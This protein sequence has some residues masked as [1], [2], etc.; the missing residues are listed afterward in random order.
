[1]G[2]WGIYGRGTH[3]DIHAETQRPYV[4]PDGHRIEYTDCKLVGF[5]THYSIQRIDGV[6]RL[7]CVDLIERQPS[8]GMWYYKPMDES[9][10]PVQTNCPLELLDICPDPMVGYST[11]WRERVRATHAAKPRHGTI[12]VGD[13]IRLIDNINP[14]YLSGAWLTVDLKSRQTIYAGGYRIKRR[15]IAEVDKT[16]T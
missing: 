11:E 8:A 6:P 15:F 13:R 7:I 16:L 9:S 2:T 1:M 5:N 10:G 4:S 3:A 14:S 12:K